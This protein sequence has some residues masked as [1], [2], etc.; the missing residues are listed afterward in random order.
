MQAT[1]PNK[2]QTI[3]NPFTPSPVFRWNYACTSEIIVNQGGTSAGK[4]YSIMQVLFLRAIQ[5]LKSIITVVAHDVPDLKAGALRDAQNIVANTEF[6]R[7]WIEKFNK[8]DRIYHFKN[9]SLMEFKS[10]ENSYDARVGKCDFLFI[11]ECNNVSFE[12]FQELQVRTNRQ[13]FLDYNPTT[14][15]WAHEHLIGKENVQLFI[16]NFMHNPFISKKVLREILNYRHTQPWRWQV[17]GLGLTGRVEG[18]IHTRVAI[19][20]A[21]PR[22]AKKITYGLDFGYTNSPTALVKME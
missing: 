3:T 9:G 22:D 1:K 10:Y 11:N 12:I 16:S 2:L 18:L 4:T 6:I 21:F 17:Y 20:N 13:T 8:A 7:L 19:C 15:F 14:W 5:Y